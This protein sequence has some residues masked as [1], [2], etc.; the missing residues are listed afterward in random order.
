MERAKE[1][2]A[3]ARDHNAQR[4]KLSWRY[5]HHLKALAIEYFEECREAGRPMRQ[6]AMDLGISRTTLGRW[7]DSRESPRAP[8][9]GFHAVRV[10]EAPVASSS[11]RATSTLRVVT[12]G[13][14]RI[15]GLDLPEVLELAR[16]WG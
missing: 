9:V 5:P 14:L 7:L 12:P 15:E 4:E 11:T 2:C 6:I 16:L 1:F 10:V 8:S 3:A 13:G